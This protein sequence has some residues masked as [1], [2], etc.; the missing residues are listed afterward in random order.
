MKGFEP[1]RLKPPG[2]VIDHIPAR[3]GRF[4]AGSPSI[5]IM[6]DGSYVAKGDDYGPAVGT[7]ELV[8]IHRSTDKG[9]TWK[10]ISEVEGLTWASLFLHRG[11]LYMMGTSAGHRLGHAVI[12]KS[13]DG[14]VNW[15]KPLDNESGL[16]LPDLSYHTAPVPVVVH[17]GRI[18]R[19]ME[20]EKG[21]GGWGTNFRAFM[22]SAPESADL[23]KAS[24]WTVSNPIGHDPERLGGNFKGWLEGNTVIGPDGTP[25][26]VLRV[27]MASGGG[28]AA[29]I[30]HTADGKTASFDATRD[31][32]SLPGAS[33]KFHI[34][35]DPESGL[36]W[37]LSNAV[38]EKHD[39]GAYGQA[40]TRNTLVVMTS[41]DLR[42]WDI[43]KT[44][45]YH[46]DICQ[47]AFQ[48]PAF[49][50][51]G[52]DIIFVARTAYDDGIGGA[53]RQHDANHFTF[54][55]IPGFRKLASE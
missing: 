46:P 32:V 54:H 5:V 49:V 26:N 44:L 40:M 27:S 25:V 2:V 16:L 11:A 14:G 50:F 20:D 43:R 45:L 30:R 35:H 42:T 13:V 53:H 51:D 4:I 31:F 21:P 12:V 10:Q 55:R 22:M 33:T 19:T 34:L 9:A 15:T 37:A 29:L 52:P 48:Y 7:S 38:P 3:T 24:S 8:R 6:E 18:W 36:Y 17:N 47:H 1:I 28:T 39:T 23:L 41:R